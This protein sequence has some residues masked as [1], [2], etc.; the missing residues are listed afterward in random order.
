MPSPS[1]GVGPVTASAKNPD[2]KI[3]CAFGHVVI[4]VGNDTSMNTRP[5]NA[6]L[7]GFLPKPPNDI[8]AMPMATTLP[9]MTIHNGRLAGTLKASKRPV[10]AAEPSLMVNGPLNKNF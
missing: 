7:N 1:N 3:G 2:S 9:T 6:G 8:L 5:T 10:K 4:A